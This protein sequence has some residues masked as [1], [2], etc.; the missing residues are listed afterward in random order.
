MEVNADLARL[1]EILHQT[2]DTIKESQK[3]ISAIA[4]EAR[5]EV[6]RL[7]R[8]LER[9]KGE[10]L[11]VIE[12]VD[13]ARSEEQRSRMELMRV[14]RDFN[15]YG[16]E[17]IRRA[18][19]RARDVQVRLILLTEK[20]KALRAQRDEIERNLRNVTRLLSRSEALT[21][22]VGVA[23]D[24]LSG[25]IQQLSQTLA[26]VQEKREI[27]V[28]VIQAQEEERRR[29]ARDL[30]DGLAQQLASALLELQVTQR[31]LQE[32][33]DKAR[34][35]LETVEKIIR[36][37]LRETRDVIFNLR[38]PS[39][40]NLGLKAAVDNLAVQ[41][42]ERTGLNVT[43]TV[44]GEEQRLEATMLSCVFR[45]IQEA[46]NNVV[47]HAEAT[48]A[49]VRIEFNPAF[50]A[51]RV[52]DNGKGFVPEKGVAK[53]AGGEHLGLL[54]MR[55]RAELIGAALRIK[56]TPGRGTRVELHLPLGEAAAE[57]GKA[58]E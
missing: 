17:D 1:E 51:V 44:H 21:A 49:Q 42:E 54:G 6:A 10:T 33:I 5:A 14:S 11:D 12:A 22:Q 40:D 7:K 39:L 50:L 45:I 41:V 16:E 25:N 46:L 43:V 47:K 38:P 2:V 56:S 28:R 55:E 32:D 3:Q 30:H 24:Y 9:V 52:V 18:Y 37:G 57:G 8:E 29:V 48:Q 4:D 19:E 26:T 53:A 34:S 27:A 20:E 23:I 13:A 36:S 31:L 58:G 35:E 15:Q